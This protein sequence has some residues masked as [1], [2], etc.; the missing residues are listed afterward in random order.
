MKFREFEVNQEMDNGKYYIVISQ[1][2]ISTKD[3]RHY[4][5]L[6]KHQLSQLLDALKVLDK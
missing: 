5:V 4:V 1:E 6:E 2:K 3:K